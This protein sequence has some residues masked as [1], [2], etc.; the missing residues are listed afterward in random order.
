MSRRR[1]LSTSGR[2]VF[3]FVVTERTREIGIRLA[4][5]ASR[6]RVRT[7][8]FR[9]TSRPTVIGVL[10]GLLL[11]G[12]AGPVLRGFLYGLSSTSPMIYVAVVLVVALTEWAASSPG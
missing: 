1:H 5:G 9:D 8:L 7:H 6:R 10:F 11:I 4:L 3:S 2:A 12:L